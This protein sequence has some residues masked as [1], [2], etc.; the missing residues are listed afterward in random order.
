M[1]GGLKLKQIVENAEWVLAIELMTAA[2]GLEYRRPLKPA[3]E[4]DRAFETIRKYVPRLGE[5]RVLSDDIR[6]LAEQ[7]QDGR[8]DEWTR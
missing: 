6:K 5:D 8:F 2:Q 7:I 4:V 3:R 1:T